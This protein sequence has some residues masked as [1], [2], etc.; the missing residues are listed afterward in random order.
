MC[1]CVC[2]CVCI[3]VRRCVRVTRADVREREKCVLEREMCKRD[4]FTRYVSECAAHGAALICALVPRNEE[5]R[6]W[7]QNTT[8][9]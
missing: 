4:V 5:I 9:T 2:V 7:D 8:Q 6:N 3:F 1:V